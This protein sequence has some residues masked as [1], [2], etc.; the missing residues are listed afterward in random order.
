VCPT[1]TV[2]AGPNGQLTKTTTLA[3]VTALPGDLHCLPQS[4][5][6][7]GTHPDPALDFSYF[8][9]LTRNDLGQ[10]TRVTQYSTS[11]D[12]RVLQ[13]ITYTAD[14]R[15][16][17]I[18]SP[19]RGTT[20][21][22]YD[23]HGRLTSITDPM[24]V[25][26]QVTATDPLS[27][28]LLAIQT[29]RP[30]APSTAFFQYDA[31]ERLQATW[32]DV[33][34][35]SSVHPSQR[36][37]YQL[38]THTT[39]G[40]ISIETLADAIT[41]VQRRTFDLVAADGQTVV[42]GVSLGDHAV[43]GV[44][45]ITTRTARATKSSFIGP[46]TDTA[47]ASL[48]SAD[49][50]TFGTTLVDTLQAG[51]G[52]AS[53]IT[54]THQANAVGTVTQELELG[55]GELITRTH[56]PGGFT[57]EVAVDAAGNVV[58]K[59]DENGV[60]HHFAY[61]ALGRIIR[62]ETPSASHHLAFDDLGRP[63]RVSRDGVG[64]LGFA[65]DPIS[66]LLVCKQRFDA[67]GA[68]IDTNTTSY[69]AIGRHTQIVGTS[70]DDTQTL[71]YDYDGHLG[72]STI[73]GQLGRQ[74]RVRGDGWERSELFDPLGRPFEQ[75]VV[76]TGWRDITSNKT[77]RPDGS[78]A[79]DTLVIADADGDVQH[80]STKETVLDAFGRVSALKVNGALL[81]TLS[82]DAEGRLAG[83][84]FASGDTLT[85]DFDP[86]THRRR[87]HA[88]TGPHATGGVRW[89]RD[90]RGLITG[91][92]YTV[93][94]SS[95]RRDYSYDGRGAVTSAATPTSTATYSYTASGLPDST[96]DLAGT[97][98]VHR[99]SNTLDVGGVVYTWD[100][101]GRVVGK[102][103]W[104]FT[105]GANGELSRAS[106]PG[107]Q[108]DYTYDDGHHRLLERIDGVPVRA[109]VAGGVLTESH[110]IEPVAI[111]GVV[112]G[113]LDNGVFAALPSDPR[114]T[115]FVGPDGTLGLATVYGVRSAPLGYAEVVDYTQL[116]RDTDLD[117]VRMGVRDYD[118]RLG[119]FL[120]PDPLFFQNLEKCV[121]SPLECSL[122]GY[123]SGN[124]LSLVDPSGM[125]EG[126]FEWLIPRVQ[127]AIEVL[128]GFGVAAAGVAACATVV[129]CIVGGLAVAYGVAVAA[130]GV[131]EMIT[132]QLSHHQVN[133][134]IASVSNQ[135][136]AND[137]DLAL[138]ALMIGRA[139]SKSPY[140][141]PAEASVPPVEALSAGSGSGDD[142]VTIY[143]GTSNVAELGVLNESGFVMSDAAR[144]AYMESRYAG[145]PLEVATGEAMAASRRAHAAAVE[146]WGGLD[147]YVQAHG[148]FGTELSSIGPRSLISWTTDQAR[149]TYFAGPNGTVLT[150]SVPRSSLLP[151]T[152]PG[153]TES[154]QLISHMLQLLR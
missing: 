68:L 38:A 86:V 37:S 42:S 127:G 12:L 126:L 82:Y 95:I 9:Q 62:V 58:R 35:S 2:T 151:Q 98:T 13:E 131:Q 152:L 71:S 26:T 110:F 25:V 138:G 107:R 4:Q 139:L 90:A 17:T 11:I 120:T 133:R 15:V 111:G 16:A 56:Q 73:G 154:E 66:G 52:H 44:A 61:D 104:H 77:Y 28:A 47:L 123:A 143:R 148:A 135:Q 92:T 72:D 114:G 18:G 87:G 67:T 89:D 113:V 129:G 76:L 78:V 33:S 65:Y 20:V 122:Y 85:F 41:H 136:T 118:P 91:E 70:G 14:H 30:D 125:N 88:L 101:A 142:L 94:G 137:F 115:P 7:A 6:V 100:D 59:T 57:A 50:R 24:G 124:P 64:A 108:I 31:Q 149:A 34:G 153:A 39:P 102:G 79:S 3:T 83:A 96:T 54:T 75:R 19:G 45:A 8:A 1:T 117:I 132:G 49:L 106:R 146:T 55:S 69:D 109:Q 80:S 105:Y 147:N 48:T 84:S 63:R 112:V 150:A 23:T 27:D 116:G 140:F 22:S 81:Y 74:S 103:P 40:K 93:A 32:D 97:R 21:A 141:A 145:A 119:Q 128:G 53:Q 51:F 134:A 130:N 43:L 144:A 5:T 29:V 121:G 46:M 60:S 36:Y 10:I 99:T